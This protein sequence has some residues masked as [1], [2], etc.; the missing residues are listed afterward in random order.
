MFRVALLLVLALLDV[1]DAAVLAL[2]A[3]PTLLLKL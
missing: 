2:A 3:V 1:A